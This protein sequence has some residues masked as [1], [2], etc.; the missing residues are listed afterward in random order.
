MALLG[1]VIKGALHLKKILASGGVDPVAAQEKVLRHHLTKAKS[2]AFGK[3]F[4]FDEILKSKD[5]RKAF[6]EK[7]PYYDY[8]KIYKEWWHR[9]LENE[10]DV[11]WPGTTDYFAL[12]SG[13]T[14][15]Q[16]KRIPVTSDMI[17]AIKD[18]SI[19]QILCL[20][21]FDLPA[22]VFEKEILMLG[23]STDLTDKGEYQ[24]GEISGISA[25]N[26]P[27]WFE[28]YY[29]P[30]KEIAS[31]SDW[32]QRVLEIAK[33]A[34]EWDIGALSGIPAWIQ[35]MLE[36]I[37]SYHNLNNIH[38]IWPNL[39]LYAT[40]GVA[41][42]PY[43]KNFEKL[44]AKPLYYIDT[45]LASEGFLAFQTRP[46]TESM[47][48]A[49][50]SGIYFEFIPFDESNFKD[51]EM[52]EKPTILT[53]DQV[54]EGKEYALI[55]STCAG[56]WRYMIGDTVR[57]TDLSIH[58]IV[59]TGRTKFFLNV[60]GSQLSVEKMNAAIKALEEDQEISI[61]EFLVSAVPFEGA[62]AH[63]WYIGSGDAVDVEKA[64]SKL[65]AY[66]KEI[67]KN[68][69]VARSKALK[70]VFIEVVPP[71]YFYEWHA[72]HHKMGGQTKTPRV[73][74]SEQFEEWEKFVKSHSTT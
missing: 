8:D 45:Y 29:K 2:T 14:G 39:T 58:E 51:G 56:A 12:S 41:F 32:D 25:S 13:T 43:R 22:E 49:L 20:S 55:I 30:G 21:N 40:G 10:P 37:I 57:F 35:L 72:D 53:I 28:S 4:D 67:N 44:L 27:F 38:D 68:Y 23:S 50:E 5:I 1:K 17:K 31:I 54:E 66:L 52:I 60:A 65:D 59:I 7:V 62:F 9:L 73:M 46:E 15:N 71:D 3:H 18:T 24:E 69:K 47:A 36:K 16:S 26:V 48:L 74:K 64:T 19:Q 33:K 34:P 6:A 11:C 63:K 70:K 42:E 61:K